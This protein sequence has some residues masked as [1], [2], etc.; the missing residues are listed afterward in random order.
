MTFIVTNAGLAAAV[1]AASSGPLIQLATFK[2]GDG[3]NYTPTA[4]QT[5]IVGN[6]LYTAPITS[7][8]PYD[9][10]TVDVTMQIPANAGPFS[11]GEV[12]VFDSAGVM[13][14]CHAYS[15]LQNKTAGLSSGVGSVR[16]M[17]CLIRL[18][19]SS[20]VFN[21]ANGTAPIDSPAFTGT[22]TAPT[23]PVDNNSLRIAT[24][25]WYMGQKETATPVMNG[26]AAVGTS[27]KW[28]AGNHVHPTDTSRA[29]LVSPAF[30][31]VPTAPTSVTTLDA[32]TQLA[33]NQF[34]QN[35]ALYDWR[36]GQQ[37]FSP[38]G[39]QKLPSGLI[40]Q[41][42]TG[43]QPENGQRVIYTGF[44]FPIPFPTAV[45]GIVQSASGRGASQPAV[46]NL[47]GGAA[48][49]DGLGYH[50]T[51]GTYWYIAWGY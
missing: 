47:T 38:N 18:E 41:W 32:T 28:A 33:T 1:S 35:R 27:L 44:S 10:N 11:F 24:T 40:I 43:V 12:A 19:Q 49:W 8:Q 26:T 13:F 39:F 34:V 15:A 25:A 2:L 3:V 23:A 51:T 4:T 9:A 6:L 14:A 31:G 5:D 37:A 17:H 46:P 50:V 21:I 36:V 30:T 16:N 20:T 45:L 42:G 7:V 48:G 29:P 22:P